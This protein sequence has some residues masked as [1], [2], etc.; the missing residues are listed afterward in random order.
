L[1]NDMEA[2]LKERHANY[3]SNGFDNDCESGF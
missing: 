2:L 1:K 3:I